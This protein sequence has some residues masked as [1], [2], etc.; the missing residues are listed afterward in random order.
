MKVYADKTYASDES[1][2]QA[3]ET[4][5]EKL[6]IRILSMDNA[7]RQKDA[8]GIANQFSGNSLIHVRSGPAG[9]WTDVNRDSLESLWRAGFA[10]EGEYHYQRIGPRWFSGEDGSV[11]ARSLLLERWFDPGDTS[12]GAPVFALNVEETLEFSLQETDY[13]I[14]KLSLDIQEADI[15]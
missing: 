3:L 4:V 6:A 2:L 12:T 5:P 7:I 10:R 11:V 1:T 14:E 9:Q 8:A 13:W 15:R